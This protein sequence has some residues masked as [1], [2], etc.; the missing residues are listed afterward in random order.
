MNFCKILFVLLSL[1][2]GAGLSDMS[3]AAADGSIGQ[4]A[5]DSESVGGEIGFDEG[6][7]VVIGLVAAIAFSAGFVHS[8]I[9]FGFGIVAIGLMPL[10]ID[11]RHTHLLVSLCA[12]PVQ[13]G[14]VW[15]YRRGVVWRPLLFALGGALVGLPLGLWL[16]N[17]INLDWL[18]RG[19]G[20]ALLMMIAYSFYNRGAARNRTEE[21]T[22][23]FDERDVAASEE[24]DDV[25]GST[26]I[27]I[28]SGFLM[29]AVTMPGPPVVA[30]ALQQDWD[31][32]Q[33]KAFVNQFLLALSVFK[34]V[35]LL[36]TA[37]ISQ[38]SAIES[39]LII[40]AALFGIAVGKRFST[41]LSAGG[42]RTLVAVGLAVVAVLLVVKG[43][44]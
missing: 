9:G 5:S 25:A 7:I 16:F 20:V 35:G 13:M 18:T 44:G 30:F 43:S 2:F 24:K 27:G 12:V 40:P 22:D 8:G 28:A 37:D 19:T 23:V 21:K 29:G 14:T 10:V 36:A 38:Q 32:E 31:Q 4:P 3:L 42:F 11:A 41:R 15:A 34:V 39:S 33:F 6:W 1:A 17:S 26:T